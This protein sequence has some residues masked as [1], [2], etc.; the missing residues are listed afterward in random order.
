MSAEER[1][2]FLLGDQVY[3]QHYAVSTLRAQL[4]EAANEQTDEVLERRKDAWTRLLATFRAVF[5]G[6]E[7]EALRLPAYGGNLF[8]PDRF[9]FLEGRTPGTSWQTTSARPLPI[10][11]LTVLHLLDA[12]QMLPVRVPGG[13]KNS[14]GTEP[15][16]PLARLEAESVNGQVAL[17]AYLKATTARSEGALMRARARIDWPG[18]ANLVVSQVWARCGQ[19]LGRRVLDDTDVSFIGS[20]L[21]LQSQSDRL[22]MR[23]AANEGRSFKGSDI[24]R[25]GFTLTSDEAGSL[26]Q[27]DQ[28]N[29][30]VIQP[31]MN[32][33]DLNSR[34]DQA[35]SRWII[36]FF[37]FSMGMAQSY[38]DC[39]RLIEE[40]VRPDRQRRKADGSFVLRRPFP[41]R[42]WHYN[43]K[44]PALYSA[45]GGLGRVLVI[46]VVTHHVSF[47]FVPTGRVYS[48]RLAVFPFDTMP[49][50]AILQSNLHEVWARAYSSNLRV[51]LNYSP[52]DCFLT[53][54]FPASLDA[55]EDVGERYYTHRQSIM[56]ARQEGL[57]KTYNR[58]HDPNEHADDI[59]RLRDLRV[60]M[61]NA[62]ALAYGWSELALGHGFHQTAQGLRFTISEGARR[63]VLGRL[64]ALNHERYAEEVAAGLHD[65]PKS[66]GKPKAAAKDG[67][68]ATKPARRGRRPSSQ[69]ALL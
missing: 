25:M 14:K 50:F 67:T 7:H 51:D 8:D 52:S 43:E 31:F 30:Q 33:E 47:A 27:S 69:A 34:H 64:L 40:R 13:G 60:E 21:S 37:D 11:N 65:G 42:Y 22:P 16:V 53:F 68:D 36:N 19:W 44:R 5:G 10:T 63:E 49:P 2:L 46:S 38:P 29:R 62:V 4:R 18:Q 55:L 32:G 20:L 23:L 59:Q 9:P 61:D 41:E 45:I 6:I 26:I 12:L 3:D 56:A 1:G 57:T 48:H 17:L 66:K 39:W 35:G 15:I 58:V 24:L 54:P 28:R